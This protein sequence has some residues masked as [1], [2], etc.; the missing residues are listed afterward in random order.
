MLFFS[1]MDKFKILST[2]IQ[3]AV[4]LFALSVHESAHAWMANRCGDPTAKN[5]GRITLNP[6]PHIDLFGTII[7]PVMLAIIGAPVFGWAKPVPVQI[8][9]M[10]NPRR[11]NLYVSAAGPVS[12]F[13]LAIICI[14]LFK[15]LKGAGVFQ[16]SPFIDQLHPVALTLFYAII[17][18]ICLAIFNLIPIPPLDGSGIVEST[19]KGRA[20][21]YFD[22][23]RPYG[24]LI[25]LMIIY[26]NILDRIAAPILSGVIRILV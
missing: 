1:T 15:I 22:R 11:G 16:L 20:L 13:L 23:I 6:I 9:N 8:Y 2:V 12:N 4:I 24:F 18:N 7:F 3:F 10:R 17:I 26:F 14:I 5:L 25:L 19:L 21:Y